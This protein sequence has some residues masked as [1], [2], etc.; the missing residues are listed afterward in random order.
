MTIIRQGVW[1]CPSCERHQAWRTRGATERLDRRCEHCGKRIRATLDRSSSGQ[2][3][4]RALHIWERASTLGLSDLEDEAVRRDE[5]SRRRGELAGSIR[6]D[7]VGTAS[8][9]ELPTIWGAGWEPSSAL[10]FPTPLNSSWARGELLKFVAERHDGHLDTAASCWDEMGAPESFGGVSF[11]QFSKSYVSSLE[12]SLQERLLTPAL[13]SLVDVEVIPR[14]SGLLHL[15]RRTARLLLDIVL[16]LRRISHYASITLEQR[17]EWQRMMMQ[18]RLVDEHLKDLSTNGIPTPD[19]GTFGGKG[20]RSTWQEGVVACASAMRRA[21]DIPEGERARADIVAP[22]IRDVGLALA[23]GQTPTEVFAAQMGKSGSY[24]DG[25]QEGSGGRDLHI[26]NW[27]K[28]VLPP[29]APLP[30]AS[31]TTTGIALAASRLSIDRFHLAPVGEGCSSN[32]EFWEAMNLAGARG[33][34]ISF[35]IQNNQIAL[36]TFV[37]A[38]SGVETYGDKGHAMGMPAWTMDGSDPGLFYASTAVAREFATSGG[39]TDPD[40]RRDDAGLR[41]RTPP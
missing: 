34:P 40:T 6:S 30:I 22:M 32:G 17:I 26:G 38:Q 36:D 24:M 37:T 2:G 7:A 12:E 21:I 31:A 29:T 28:G 25:G 1:R 39:G 23:M 13:S 10:E 9:S 33:L 41:A 20:F 4:H 19:G 14:R 35:M 27:E 8:Q 5:E 3:R 18:T 11:Y 15:E 16:C